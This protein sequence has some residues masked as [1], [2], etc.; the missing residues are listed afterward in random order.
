VTA[1]SP[2]APEQRTGPDG[3]TLQRRGPATTSEQSYAF[4]NQR[5]VQQERLAALEELLDPGST[6]HLDALG[7]EQGWRVLEV[8]AGAGS[9]A[10]WLC[11]RV[12]PGGSVLA[13]DLDPKLLAERSHPCLEVQQH[14]IESDAAP[15]GPFD[16]AHLRLLLAWLDEPARALRRIVSTLAPGGWLLAEEMDFISV[17]ANAHADASAAAIFDRVIDIHNTVLARDHRFDPSC[18]RSLPQ[19]LADAGLTDITCEGRASIWRGGETGARVWKLTLAQLREPMLATGDIASSD[20]D[21]A[22]ELCDDPQFTFLSQ[23]TVAAWGRRHD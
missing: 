8:G 19:A 23:I 5:A 14:D 22:L 4:V 12:A 10:V 6:R 20:L 9:I 2:T 15:S 18:G 1:W 21:L 7:I 13:T 3:V 17:S 11:D 16:L